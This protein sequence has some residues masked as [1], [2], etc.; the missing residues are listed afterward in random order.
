MTCIAQSSKAQYRIERYV[1]ASDQ[2]HHLPLRRYKY[3]G[4]AKSCVH[5]QRESER[6]VLTDYRLLRHIYLYTTVTKRF[7]IHQ[8]TVHVPNK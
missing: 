5:T 4:F 3:S 8:L 6:G 7:N 1:S 2:H